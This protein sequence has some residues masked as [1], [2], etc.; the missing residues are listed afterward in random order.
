MTTHKM[1]DDF[2]TQDCGGKFQDKTWL[3][4]LFG[5]V[6]YTPTGE[7]VLGGFRYFK[8]EPQALLQAFQAGDL[9]GISRLPYALEEDGSPDTS[10]LLIA[11]HYTASGSA[12][13][14]QVQGYQD[15]QP[16]ALGPTVLLEGDAAKA[17]IGQVRA[18]DQSK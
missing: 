1:L 16:V 17:V 3:F 9:A 8:C 2:L 6:V 7:K 15:S 11:L 5:S 10:A 14:M 12:V 13:A 4:G 18:I